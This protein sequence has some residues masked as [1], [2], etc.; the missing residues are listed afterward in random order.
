MF[1]LW[2]VVRIYRLDSRESVFGQTSQYAK[3]ITNKKKQG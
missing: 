1:A 3:Y 2:S